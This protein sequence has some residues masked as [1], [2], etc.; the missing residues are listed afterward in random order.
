MEMLKFSTKIV[1][2]DELKIVSVSTFIVALLLYVVFVACE[3]FLKME[4]KNNICIHLM[5]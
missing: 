2:G 3:I 5:F 1:S 4:V